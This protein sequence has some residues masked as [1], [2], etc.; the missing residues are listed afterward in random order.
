MAPARKN[1]RTARLATAL[2]FRF[3]TGV[4]QHLKAFL[5]GPFASHLLANYLRLVMLTSRKTF[6]LASGDRLGDINPVI[7]TSWHGHSYL[8]PFMFRRGTCP[9]L[10]VARHGDGRMVGNAMNVLGM[11]LTFGSGS[12]DKTDV[13]KGGAKAFLTLLRLL[14]A[15]K[16][17][18]ITA[19]VPKVS[20]VTGQGV[21]LLARKSGVPVVPVAMA[22]S[23]RIYA[24]SWDRMQ[25]NLPF[26][27]I[28]LVEG[29][30]IIVPDDDSPLEAHQAALTAALEAA[31]AQA[32]AI[33]DRKKT[34]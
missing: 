27:R 3:M 22:S 18:K 14:K 20:R 31:E 5:R 21:I 17:I 7:Y 8:F 19:D 2:N 25:I 10:L 34:G 26:S 6:V 24:K 15:G 4:K 32:F 28:A 29:A 11:P 16:S 9:T 23:R 13:N 1:A 30:P 12:N 33:V